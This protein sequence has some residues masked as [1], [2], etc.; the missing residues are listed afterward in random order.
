MRPG[1]SLIC[2]LLAGCAAD[3][4]IYPGFFGQNV[5]GNEAFV[6]VSNVYNEQDAFPLA[7]DHCRKYGKVS[8]F[9]RMENFRA[10]F[11]CLNPKQ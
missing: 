5:V 4:H 3:A 1:A 10:I 9:S 7:E 6:S 8:R 2:L 11:D